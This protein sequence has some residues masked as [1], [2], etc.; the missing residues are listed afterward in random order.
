MST[1]CDSKNISPSTIPNV[2]CIICVEEVPKRKIVKCP[3]CE[4]ESCMNCVESFLMGI[5]DNNPRCMNNSCKKVWTYEFLSENFNFNFHNK[6][7]RE[8]RATILHEREKSLLP[9]TQYLVIQ[10]KL[11]EKNQINIKKLIDENAMYRQLITN[12]N[13][14]IRV[15][16]ND[17]LKCKEKK[18]TFI[19]SCP[20]DDCRGF[21]STS[22]KCGT[23]GIRACKDCHMPKNEEHKCDPDL[24]ATVKL[25]SKNTKPC[26][27]CATL[28]YKI[29]GCDQMYCT[30]CHTAF[31][32]TRGTIDRGVIHNPHFYIVQKEMN[33]GNAPRVRGDNLRCGG[34]PDIWQIRYALITAGVFFPFTDQAHMLI[35]RITHNELPRYPHIIGEVDNSSLRVDYLMGRINE[36]QWISKLKSKMKKQEKN[37][38]INMVLSMFTQTMSDIFGNITDGKTD[39]VSIQIAAIGTLLEYT[40]KSLRKIG[41]RYGNVYPCISDNFEFLSNSLKN[42]K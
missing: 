34:P 39:D 8:R 21:L 33:G 31:S 42:I 5:D 26:P 25:L 36:K 11:R 12:N 4:F 22:L 40:N 38:E 29:N 35:N 16:M 24:V 15:L 3:F 32:W 1:N 19:R 9:G 7:Y 28:I 30:Q 18:N 41:L 20:V 6:K 17:K 13:E 10:E 2:E 14:K 27:A 23:C 37:G